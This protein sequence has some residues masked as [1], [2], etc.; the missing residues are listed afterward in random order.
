VRWIA[1]AFLIGSGSSSPMTPARPPRSDIQ[2]QGALRIQ[3][4][5]SLDPA[6]GKALA[7]FTSSRRASAIRACRP[8][9]EELFAAA[10]TR[11][12]VWSIA[13]GAR[14]R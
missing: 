8:R 11:V 12:F 2:Q 3:G 1:A 7:P 6:I 14:R 5:P 10:R 9:P 4:A 13:V